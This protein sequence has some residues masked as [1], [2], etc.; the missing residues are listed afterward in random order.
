MDSGSRSLSGLGPEAFLS[1]LPCGPLHRTAHNW[2]LTYSSASKREV[3]GQPGQQP[4]SFWNLIPKVTSHHLCHTVFTRKKLL[5]PTHS[6]G[7]GTTQ[8]PKY[9]KAGIVGCWYLR[10]CP[11]YQQQQNLCCQLSTPQR[12][13]D[14]HVPMCTH[15]HLPRANYTRV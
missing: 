13:T 10:R 9:Q 7:E 15:T 3:G 11:T 6:Q 12:Q 4:Q 5:N 1:A 8:G 2:Q 14:T